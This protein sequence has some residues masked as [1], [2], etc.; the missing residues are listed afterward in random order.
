M[1]DGA[2]VTGNGRLTGQNIIRVGENGNVTINPD[3]VAPPAAKLNVI[4]KIE[5]FINDEVG[6]FFAPNS[7]PWPRTTNPPGALT[8]TTLE[9]SVVSVPGGPEK[10]VKYTLGAEISTGGNFAKRG[11]YEID[12]ITYLDGVAQSDKPMA[13]KLFA[14]NESEVVIMKSLRRFY[15]AKERGLP[16]ADE[17]HV[18][19]PNKALITNNFNTGGRAAVSPHNP[20]NLVQDG[21]VLMPNIDEVSLDMAERLALAGKNGLLAPYDASELLLPT[22][23]PGIANQKKP[24]WWILGDTDTLETTAMNDPYVIGM[25]LVNLREMLIDS[26]RRY[27]VPSQVEQYIGIVEKNITSVLAKYGLPPV[28]RP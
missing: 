22:S 23:N 15:D 11:I 26:I 7:S 12:E 18:D 20:T 4:Q 28:K 21:S 13:A 1:V 2:M 5:E 3:Y 25:N 27:A 24:M 10:A 9:G 8:G 14:E 6:S 16:V 17:I 19:L